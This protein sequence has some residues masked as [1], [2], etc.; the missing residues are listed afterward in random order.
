M[1]ERMVWRMRGNGNLGEV[2]KDMMAHVKAPTDAEVETLTRYLQKHAQ[3]EID[4]ET[5]RARDAG[6]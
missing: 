6:R 5:P 4:P 2:M 1:V 3:A